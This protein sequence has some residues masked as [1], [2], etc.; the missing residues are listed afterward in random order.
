MRISFDRTKASRVDSRERLELVYKNTNIFRKRE[1]NNDFFRKSPK[2]NSRMYESAVDE[3][4]EKVL[5]ELTRNARVSST[6]LAKRFGVS[7]ATIHNRLRRLRD[8]GIW[9]SSHAEIDMTKLGFNVHA[10]VSIRL[11]PHSRADL[12]DH[13]KR[14]ASKANTMSIFV[15][16]GPTDLLIHIV[17][18]ST[19]RL[20]EI[21]TKE[22]NQDEHVNYADTQVVY[23]FRRGAQHMEKLNG[24][25]DLRQ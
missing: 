6:E 2:M 23:S 19:E 8:I 10:L 9:E 17:C 15:L 24:F 5:W 13:M 21:V 7:E 11:K 20:Y 4:D 25:D 12:A 14:F 18:E 1:K 16:G 22:F 3:L